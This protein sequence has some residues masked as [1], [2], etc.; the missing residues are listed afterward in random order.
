LA[1]RRLV[2]LTGGTGFLGSHLADA[3]LAERWR[4]RALVRRPESPGWL[5]GLDVE[6]AR[7]DVRDAGALDALVVGADAVI[8]VAGKTSARS[9]A[10]YFAANAGG[11][12]NVVAATLRSSPAA[13]L[14]LVSSQAAG[15][16]SL[17]GLPVSA[18]APGRPVSSYGRSKLEAENE[19]RKATRLAYTILRPSAVYGPRETAIRDLF[20]AASRGVVPVLAGGRPR[21][22]MVYIADFVRSV[23][24]AL[25]R[26]GKQE[27]FNVAHPE[28]LDYRRIA[29]TLAGLP[30]RRPLLLPVPG[31]LIRAA[32]WAIGAA[33]AFSSG[34]PVF[35]G[36]KAA[37]MLQ[38]AWLSYVGDAQVAL[39]QPFETDFAHGSRLTWNWYVEKGWIRG[40]T[41]AEAE[42]N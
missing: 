38:P 42:R 31:S 14:V 26:G 32:G 21:V 8:H 35:N 9:E 19:V 27:T 40:D 37:E 12:A 5:K 39:G 3:F 1:P 30:S 34:P 36:E 29:L 11:T 24:G 10:E 13:H 4:V 33:S 22:Q 6:V 17:D 25:R 15:G 20:V 2:A 41:I 7:G 16:P 28:V 23:L 18:A